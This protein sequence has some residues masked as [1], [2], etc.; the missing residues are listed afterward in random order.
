MESIS[1]ISAQ[2]KLSV[3]ERKPFG[4]MRAMSPVAQRIKLVR[5]LHPKLSQEQ[6]AELLGVTRGAVGNWELGKGIKA[7]NMMK[8]AAKTGVPFEWLFR[9]IG[10]QP[11]RRAPPVDPFDGEITAPEGAVFD[12]SGARREIPT[13]GIREL[14]VSAGLGG[15]QVPEVW[16]ESREGQAQLTDPVKPEP[17]VLP[18]RFVREGMGAPVERIIAVATKGDSM[19]PTIGNGDVVFIDTTNKRVGSGT[20]HAIR[21][22]YGEIIIKRLDLR[23]EGGEYLVSVISDNKSTPTKIEPISEVAVI[24][25]VCGLF[26]LM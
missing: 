18:K 20:L 9:G 13:G 12:G 4:T 16:Y 15:G 8:V 19:K 2:V 24:G 17:W 11:E 21:D 22:A 5:E 14:D 1:F 3:I 7:E 25:R 10:P 23:R 26:K 6:F